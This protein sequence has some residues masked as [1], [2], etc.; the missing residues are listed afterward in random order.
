MTNGGQKGHGPK[1]IKTER[2]RKKQ[3]LQTGNGRKTTGAN[4]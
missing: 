2:P 3:K 1:K 4:R